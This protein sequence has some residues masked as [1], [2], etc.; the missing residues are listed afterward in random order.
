MKAISLQIFDMPDKQSD[1]IDRK[2]Y[3]VFLFWER[4]VNFTDRKKMISFLAGASRELTYSMTEI[5]EIST[6][7]FSLASDAFISIDSWNGS[8]FASFAVV[9]SGLH[10]AVRSNGPNSHVYI[11]KGIYDSIISLTGICNRLIMLYKAKNQFLQ[12]RKLEIMLNRIN[13]VKQRIDNIGVD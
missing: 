6:E 13:A 5:A 10:R 3:G 4:R 11:F 7:L 9:Y 8:E 2:K 12:V 1:Y